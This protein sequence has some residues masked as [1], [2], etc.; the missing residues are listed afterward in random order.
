[1]TTTEERQWRREL[2]IRR[3]RIARRLRVRQW[4]PQ[5][6]PMFR[7]GNIHYELSRRDRHPQPDTQI[8]HGEAES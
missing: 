7:G 4:T 2:R 5:G 8:T 6:Q 3:R 1:M